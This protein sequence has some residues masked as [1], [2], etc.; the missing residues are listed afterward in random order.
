ML[1]LLL[2][3]DTIFLFY[4]P[5]LVYFSLTGESKFEA[6]FSVTC[7]SIAAIIFYGFLA[8]YSFT[9][10]QSCHIIYYRAQLAHFAMAIADS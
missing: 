8:G 9:L 1:S 5:P 3:I 2:H 4:Q 10:W 6:Q 7:S